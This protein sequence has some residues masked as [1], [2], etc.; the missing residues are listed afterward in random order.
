MLVLNFLL[1]REGG[2][3]GLLRGADDA[4]SITS[5]NRFDSDEIWFGN[6]K[7]IYMTLLTNCT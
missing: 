5:S 4:L 6:I 3:L 1:I 2:A 7:G